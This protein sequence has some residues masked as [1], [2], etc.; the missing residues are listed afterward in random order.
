[1]GQYTTS[2]VYRAWFGELKF[3]CF[4]SDRKRK[5]GQ[6]WQLKIIDNNREKTQTSWLKKVTQVDDFCHLGIS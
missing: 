1:M 6:R 4:L 5:T 2:N 3:V